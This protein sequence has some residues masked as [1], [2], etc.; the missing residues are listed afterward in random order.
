M[1]VLR[2]RKVTVSGLCAIVVTAGALAGCQ[3]DQPEAPNMFGTAADPQ[4][5]GSVNKQDKT[6]ENT[7]KWA[8]YWEKNPK[9]ADAAISYAA[10]LKALNKPDQAL[11]VLRKSAMSSPE[12]PVILAA[13]GKQL[14]AMGQLPEANKVLTKA[15]KG[16]SPT[17]QVFSIHG[18]VLDRLGKHEEARTQY[19]AA[20]HLEPD[21]TS[22]INNMAM[23]HAMS[24]DPK[25]AEDMLLEAVAKNS[26]KGSAQLQQ[27]LALV[28]G[29]QGDFDRARK[30]LAK[31]LPPH[32]VEANMV[33]IKKMISQPNTWKQ[34]KS[35]K[36]VSKS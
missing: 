14:A 8:V 10:H 28:L 16:P 32:Q 11:G 29:L 7:Q 4:T 12:N 20:L 25:A 26:G 27:N 9:D 6:L 24:G 19:K 13:Y 36:P 3:T 22:V 21:N 35:A 30:V 1:S 33:Y 15:A 31:V 2:P 18:T 23:S 5:T 17:W 34:I